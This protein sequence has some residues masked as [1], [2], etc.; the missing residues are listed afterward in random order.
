VADF[1]PDVA[2]LWNLLGVGGLGLVGWLEARA[3]PWVWHLMDAVPRQLCAVDEDPLP[4]AA[5]AFAATASGSYLACSRHVLGE[6]R[7]GGFELP[8]TVRLVP[9]WV[10]GE[11]PA[12]RMSFYSPGE[13]ELRITTAV[14]VLVEHKGIDI[15]I[16]AAYR[17]RMATD[18]PFSVDI[19]GREDDDRFRALASERGLEDLVGF[20]G[21]VEQRELM[22]RL[23]S[24]DVFAF[25]TEWREP[26][27]FAPLEA[28]AAG[29]VPL[30]SGTCGNAEWT[31]DRV[32][33]LKAARDAQA[34]AKALKA[35]LDGELPLAPIARRAQAMVRSSFALA[36]VYP[37]I[38]AAL[39]EAITRRASAASERLLAAAAAAA[40]TP[41]S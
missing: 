33:C 35:I 7:R 38:E 11:L 13:R 23:S 9:N 32:H 6:I 14:G 31:V 19:Y 24:Y 21:I 41:L 39:R 10:A 29:S 2:Y 3:I 18:E 1:A 25:P 26:F 28:A 37:R 17:L 40:E 20:N 34:F 16:D 30:I 22:R 4:R 27:A 5:E 15:L 8:G 36:A 12:P